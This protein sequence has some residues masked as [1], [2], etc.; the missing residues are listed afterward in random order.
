MSK[1]RKKKESMCVRERGREKRAR[2]VTVDR[3]K[4]KRGLKGVVVK[5]SA[6]KSE[7]PRPWWNENERPTEKGQRRIF[8]DGGFDLFPQVRFVQ[9]FF[10]FADC[11]FMIQAW[12]RWGAWRQN[13]QI[14]GWLDPTRWKCSWY[15]KLLFIE[16]L[17]EIDLRIQKTLRD[18]MFM[19][20]L[21]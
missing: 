14:P 10:S 13:Q 21:L 7:M 18:K 3:V 6:W 11:Q 5:P 9:R 16:R 2:G 1:H 15:R 4:R 8:P 12:L 19:A 17:S 20:D